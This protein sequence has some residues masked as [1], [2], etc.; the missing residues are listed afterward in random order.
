MEWLRVYPGAPV[1]VS[2]MSDETTCARK[3]VKLV[4]NSEYI[5]KRIAGR[6]SSC[7]VAGNLGKAIFAADPLSL[8]R[9]ILESSCKDH[10]SSD[11]RLYI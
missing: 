4:N 2:K 5:A 10:G 11:L 9:Q 3:N 1:G 6:Y 8:T 7:L